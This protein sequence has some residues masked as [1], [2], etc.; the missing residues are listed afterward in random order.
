MPFDSQPRGLGLWHILAMLSI[1]AALATVA[2]QNKG[3][4]SKDTIDGKAMTAP[5]HIARLNAL[6]ESVERVMRHKVALKDSCTLEFTSLRRSPQG[7]AF[8]VPL[9]TLDTS[10]RTDRETGLRL[11]ELSSLDGPDAPTHAVY[12]TDK[13]YDAIAYR[14]HLRQLTRLCVETQLKAAPHLSARAE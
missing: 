8:D 13:W 1:A 3:Y 7:N 14:S 11:V 4:P 5:E 6:G 12:Q 10:A 9:L 2:Y